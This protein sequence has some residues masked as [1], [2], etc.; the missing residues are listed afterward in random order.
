VSTFQT[1]IEIGDPAG[2]QFE[3]LNALVD[4][5]A[6]Y[7]VVPASILER[8]GVVVHRTSVF[9]FADGRQEEWRM[10]RTWIRLE[11][12]QEMTLVVFGVEGVAPILGAV[13]L[14]ELLLGVDP[15][16]QKLIPVTGLMMSSPPR[17]VV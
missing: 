7:T 10:G 16:K 6:T 14:E 11:D 15:V 8:L 5:G 3:S 12:R 17:A 1:P 4:T 9:E 13:T 2:Q